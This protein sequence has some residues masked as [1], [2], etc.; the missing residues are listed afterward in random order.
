MFV[1]PSVKGALI[2]ISGAVVAYKLANRVA[3]SIEIS[4]L[5]RYV[6]EQNEN[7]FLKLQTFSEHL[8]QNLEDL[9]RQRLVITNNFDVFINT[10]EKINNR[11][12]FFAL[13]NA[14]IPEFTF[15][16]IKN[17]STISEEMKEML[18]DV[19]EMSNVIDIQLTTINSVK[20]IKEASVEIC[21]GIYKELVFELRNLVEK[22]NDW[23]DYSEDERL[24]VENNI[25]AVQILYYLNNIL[26]YKVCRTNDEGEIVEV[27]PNTEEINNAVSMAKDFQ[28]KIKK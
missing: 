7:S 10:F 9:E 24:L 22:K 23:N 3:N 17:I 14:Q 13:E 18:I 12:A 15:Q 11:Q 8:N 27:E 19:V 21:N 16:N 26:L 28:N 1:L 25:K 5:N 4:A 6:R 2:T 20:D